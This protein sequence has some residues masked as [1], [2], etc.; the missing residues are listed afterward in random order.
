M[1][2]PEA[3]FVSALSD[4]YDFYLFLQKA[5]YVPVHLIALQPHSEVKATL[6]LHGGEMS[7]N[8]VCVRAR[9]L[10]LLRPSAAEHAGVGN[11]NWG[12]CLGD[13]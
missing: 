8:A 5:L 9:A 7:Q 6:I 1:Q 13:D 2:N 12:I 10:G 4:Q 11:R 3:V